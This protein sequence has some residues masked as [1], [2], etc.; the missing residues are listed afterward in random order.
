MENEEKRCFATLKDMD[1]RIWRAFHQ[2][3]NYLLRMHIIIT[4]ILRSR[5]LSTEIVLN[6]WIQNVH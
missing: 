6:I 4:I 1:S 2:K 5:H 3:R